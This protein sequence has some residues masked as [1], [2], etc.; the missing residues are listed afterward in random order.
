[1]P[2]FDSLA[3]GS[4]AGGRAM[5]AL[6]FLQSSTNAMDVYSALNSSPWT[7]ESFGADPDKRASCLEYVHHSLAVTA[8]YSGA[9]AVL[10]GSWWPVI[11]WAIASAYMYW[12]YTRALRRAMDSG[13]TSWD[14]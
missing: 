10:A 9:A 2:N 14:S 6:L 13:S 12:L 8:G 5:A 11:G 1:M 7:A 3:L 4:N